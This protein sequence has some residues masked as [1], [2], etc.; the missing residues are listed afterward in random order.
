MNTRSCSI[1]GAVF[2]CYCNIRASDSDR[3]DENSSSSLSE[4]SSYENVWFSS[5][6]RIV[7]KLD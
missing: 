2:C 3:G 1:I 4:V 5:S 6:K 7:A